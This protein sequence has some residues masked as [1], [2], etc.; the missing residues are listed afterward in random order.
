VDTSFRFRLVFMLQ[1][2]LLSDFPDN[3]K[4]NGQPSDVVGEVVVVGG[5]VAGTFVSKSL[6]SHCQVVLIEPYALSLSREE[7]LY[8]IVFLLSTSNL[9]DKCIE[10]TSFVD[11]Y[12]QMMYVPITT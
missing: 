8:E 9:K 6:R 7:V 11:I 3:S 12:L 1:Q 5:G 2:I 10:Y 4:K